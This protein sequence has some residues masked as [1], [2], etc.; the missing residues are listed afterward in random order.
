MVVSQ[1]DEVKVLDMF[2]RLADGG[3][4]DA[5]RKVEAIKIALIAEESVCK[6][7]SVW[8][9]LFSSKANLKRINISFMVVACAQGSG[10]SIVLYY[11]STL[12]EQAWVTL[13][14]TQRKV[15]IIRSVFC[16]FVCA[17]GCIT[18]E[19]IGRRPQVLIEI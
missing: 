16:L 14:S 3:V 6:T 8:K 9:E 17:I 12:M 11:V 2:T 19:I 15:A 7:N 10:S 13:V 1:Q 4:E 18:F 5:A